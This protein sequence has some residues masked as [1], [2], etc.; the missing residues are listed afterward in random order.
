LSVLL[1]DFAAW[2]DLGVL[3]HCCW[4][5]LFVLDNLLLLFESFS[6]LICFRLLLG[7]SF[8]QYFFWNSH[9]NSSK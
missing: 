4:G 6:F 2:S 5:C 9:F 7:S 8:L 1:Q 3:E